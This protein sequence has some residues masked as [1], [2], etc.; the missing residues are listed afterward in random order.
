MR[1]NQEIAW[2]IV[3]KLALNGDKTSYWIAYRA[4]RNYVKNEPL[5]VMDLLD[6]DEY[7]YKKR[8]QRRSD[9]QS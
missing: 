2:P 6:V 8:I 1:V 5:K 7:K 4:C 9:G 3:E